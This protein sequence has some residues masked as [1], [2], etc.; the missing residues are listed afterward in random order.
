MHLWPSSDLAASAIFP[1]LQVQFF[2]V[3]CG[4]LELFAVVSW[5]SGPCPLHRLC[6]ITVRPVSL[7]PLNSFVLQRTSSF[8]P[9]ISTFRRECKKFMRTPEIGLGLTTVAVDTALLQSYLLSCELDLVNCPA[10][11]HWLITVHP[12]TNPVFTW[13]IQ[14]TTYSNTVWVR[15]RKGGW[16][17][18]TLLVPSYLI[19]YCLLQFPLKMCFQVQSSL[20]TFLLPTN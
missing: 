16:Y 2:A 19:F 5:H 3:L 7:M 8:A 13:W 17:E 1:Q 14:T 6:S 12:I 11:V 15:R 20:N 4:S 10:S 9:R 18:I